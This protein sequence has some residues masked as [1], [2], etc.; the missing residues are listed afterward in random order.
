MR[1]ARAALL[2]LCGSPIDP[3][4][5]TVHGS[6]ES[7]EA[8][9]RLAPTLRPRPTRALICTCVPLD[10][11]FRAELFFESQTRRARKPIPQRFGAADHHE[12]TCEIIN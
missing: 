3:P 10:H 11:L 7:V 1:V 4:K 6:W 12:A 5:V 9:S 8:I 2:I